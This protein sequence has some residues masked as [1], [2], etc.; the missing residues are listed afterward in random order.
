MRMKDNGKEVEDYGKRVV[1]MID[2]GV[3]LDRDG[4]KCR[5]R[6]ID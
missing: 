2:H 6:V 5:N 4:T 1:D 3:F